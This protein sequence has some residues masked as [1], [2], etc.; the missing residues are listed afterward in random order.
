MIPNS[1]DWSD[2]IEVYKYPKSPYPLP[3]IDIN[4][5]GVSNYNYGPEEI[6]NS[7]GTINNRFWLVYFDPIDMMVK[8]CASTE[9]YW[10]DPI[11]LFEL[12]Y[13][14]SEVALTFDQLGRPHV[15]FNDK[16]ENARLYWYDP[17][18][19]MADIKELGKGTSLVA[20]FDSIDNTSETFSDILLFYVKNDTVYMRIQRDRF[21]VEYPTPA[22]G[23]GVSIIE[24]GINVNS[25][26][27]ISYRTE[28]DKPTLEV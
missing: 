13:I 5:Y 18:S 10:E 27:Q 22:T 21:D 20:Q 14:I 7:E 3:E 17:T 9:D 19:S 2:D 12:D 26:F 15:L 16:E 28:V 23:V 24:S 1:P 25:R 8:L 4:I 11:N 6:G